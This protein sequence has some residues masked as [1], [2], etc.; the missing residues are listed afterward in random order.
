[1]G[2]YTKINTIFKR[3]EQNA[4]IPTELTLDVFKATKNLLYE[5]TE[6]IDGT[7]M[8][9]EIDWRSYDDWS[10]QIKGKTDNANIPKTLEKRMHEIFDGIKWNEVFDFNEPIHITI[11]GEG[12]G[13]GIQKGGNYIPNGVD[14]ILFDVNIGGLWLLR[15]SLEDIARKLGVDIVPF[16]G[17]FTI[18]D[19]CKYVKNGFKSTIAENKDYIAEGLV[20]KAPCGLLTRTGERLIT[21]IKYKDFQEFGRKHPDINLDEL[22]EQ[23]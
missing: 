4:I 22:I 12:Y 18:K 17:Y 5:G 23:I 14:F 19:A 9:V 15:P 13:A 7:N 21:K 10:V 20:L 2:Q 3:D 11:Y 8:R 1:M 16:I 6:K